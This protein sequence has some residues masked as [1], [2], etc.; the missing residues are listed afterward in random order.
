MTGILSL[1]LA[2]FFL[3]VGWWPFNP[4]PRNNVSWLTDNHGLVLEHNSVVFDPKPLPATGQVPNP[5]P[6]F[7]V[8]LSF[9][10]AAEPKF[11]TA[12]IL[13]I[14]NG[15]TP[16]NLVICQWKSALLVRIPGLGRG[17]RE[18]GI[19]VLRK[20][21]PRFITIS[22]NSL[23]TTF[24]VDGRMYEHF[25][26]YVLPSEVFKGQ[27][28]FGN[29]ATGKHE[30]AGILFGL[31]LFDR[32][33]DADEVAAHQSLWVKGAGSALS[34][35]EGLLALYDF[36]EG[37]G[38]QVTDKSPNKHH[39]VIPGTYAVVENTMLEFPGIRLPL[40][41]SK[42]TDII[43]NIIG[44]V[45]FGII[46]FQYRRSVSSYSPFAV[47][48]SV[49]FL[50]ALLSLIIELGQIWLPTRSS[51]AADLILNTAG[52]ICGV[53]VAMRIPMGSNVKTAER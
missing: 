4:F 2:V 30:W 15:R 29:A 27:L 16:S 47:A 9:E 7:T 49:T 24:Y 1:A 8:E 38:Q 45:P 42:I 13:T 48:L 44:F 36:D 12:S 26:G 43:L 46:A 34:N 50:G 20:R 37:E 39:L 23:G 25:P 51:S 10:P 53:L 3:V 52:T 32:A 6:G 35:E 22:S 14:H 40:T 31:A 5:L 33:L 21:Q 28:I 19:D 18:V 11:N 17:F 41:V